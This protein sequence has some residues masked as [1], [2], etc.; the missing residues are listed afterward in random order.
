M[1]FLEITS[2]HRDRNRFPNPSYFEVP[3]KTSAPTNYDGIYNAFAVYPP[4]NLSVPTTYSNEGYIYGTSMYSGTNDL[5]FSILPTITNDTYI[6]DS[7]NPLG[8]YVG[9]YLHLVDS[10]VA[11]ATARLD[12]FRLIT[13]YAVNGVQEITGTVGAVNILPSS[14]DLATASVDL[15]NV[16]VGFEL[17]FIT[18]TDPD[19]VGVIRNVSF[20]RGFDSRI[21]L[22]A[23][24]NGITITAG[25][26]FILRIPNYIFTI[27]SPFSIGALPLL[28]DNLTLADNTT[29]RIQ[30]SI[31]IEQGTLTSG[32][33]TTAVLPASVGS[34][35]YTGYMLW[36]TS[37]PLVFS[38]EFLDAAAIDS[39]GVQVQGTWTIVD[40]GAFPDDYFN[41]MTLTMTSGAFAGY[42]YIIT[43]W[44]NATQT[45]T[46]TPGWTSVAATAPVITDTYEIRQPFPNN[47]RR[48]VS[49][50]TGTRT[51]TVSP[52]F[53]Y[54]TLSN[55]DVNYAVTSSTTFE[56][57]SF[58]VDNYDGLD[59]AE[60]M[61]GQQ[62][63]QC[64]E[65][66][67]VHLSFPNQL[68]TTGKRI[69][70]YPFL[71]VKFN[72]Q[73][74]AN[75]IYSNSPVA[76]EKATFK[77]YADYNYYPDVASFSV[78]S[79]FQENQVI[80]FQPHEGIVFGV[81]LPNG[82][83]VQFPDEYFSPSEPN[84]QIQITALFSIEIPDCKFS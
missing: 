3:F 9:K 37:D 73:G 38:G 18:A 14:F 58:Q 16:L 47:Y 66:K 81:Y 23:A 76:R 71:Y 41:N 35:D 49:Y 26:V 44:D 10:T 4:P 57:L 15:E 17:E 7:Y 83:L 13:G 42:S 11:S 60:S 56:L 33:T 75:D 6:I 78:M 24:I 19:L 36:I 80:K 2:S 68:M 43:N 45:G 1:R 21:Y 22:D 54:H 52:P 31:S 30:D 64:R 79:G 84:E 39:G 61:L 20:F 48:I 69:S 63:P 59:Y 77:A 8:D 40:G 29:Y 12:E 62:N 65:I 50:N 46:I 67:L 51:A 70:Q 28:E 74:N 5:T 34:V 25:D 32:T 53:T 27:D 82:D 72:N 55:L